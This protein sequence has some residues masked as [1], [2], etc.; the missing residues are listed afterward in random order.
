MARENIM[1]N[2]KRKL[3]YY[4]E[5]FENER[6]SIEPWIQRKELAVWSAVVLYL[7][8]LFSVTNFFLKAF[9][10]KTITLDYF[11]TILLT[12]SMLL[13]I[14]FIHIQ[15]GYIE[16]GINNQRAINF[17]IITIINKNRIPQELSFEID[18]NSVNPISRVSIANIFRGDKLLNKYLKFIPKETPKV[19]PIRQK[20]FFFRLFLP[21]RHVIN[22]F[23]S[24]EK[25]LLK[26]KIIKE[27]NIS[28]LEK[29]EAIVY[30]LIILPTISIYFYYF[31]LFDC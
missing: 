14:Y 28:H 21:I 19:R 7:T 1:E 9:E 20:N 24:I 3:D 26:L 30:D 12:I 2:N 11:F 17:W 22:K 5:Y 23:E 15:F 18:E 4:L 25:L 27:F 8:G 29:E 13:F 31:L 6:K 10:Y 16:C